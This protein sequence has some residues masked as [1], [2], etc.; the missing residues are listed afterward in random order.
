MSAR[1]IVLLRH[2]RTAWN[3][4]RR[5][6]GQLDTELDETG[7]EQARAVAPLVAEL[8]PVRIVS[9]DLARAAVTAQTV[10]KVCGL[11]PS[12]DE[13]LREFRLGDLQGLTHDELEARDPAGF[14]R[15]R[16]GDWDDLPGAE[17]PA[18]V[19]ARFTAALTDLAAGLGPGECGVAVS[20]GAATRTG[21]VA[22]LG[23]PLTVATDLRGLGNCGRVVLDE[24]PSGAW[25]LS[26]YNA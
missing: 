17:T 5:V 13:R 11:E 12:Y 18:E 20:H 14:A 1:R 2:G 15:F 9:S 23:W 7:L 6:Q 21:V 25:A 24:R 22:F 8:A 16:G 3:A 10:A 4:A 19:A 26:S